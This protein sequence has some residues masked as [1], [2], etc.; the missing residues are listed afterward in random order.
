MRMKR[1]FAFII[2]FALQYNIVFSQKRHIYGIVKDA[3]NKQSVGV[4]GVTLMSTDSVFISGANTENDGSFE[5][6]DIEDVRP[7]LLKVSCTGYNTRVVKVLASDKDVALG[8]I[9]IESSSVELE[10]ITVTASSQTGFSDRKM[11]YP[12]SRQVRLSENG[13]GLLREMMIP[14]ID[15][16]S[17]R[18]TVATVD[19]GEVQ[20][21]INDVEATIQDI[22]ALQP[23]EVKRIE[24]L[25]N[26][27]LRYGNAEVVLNYIVK[28]R[29]SG[30]NFSADIMQSVTANWGNYQMSG[31]VNHRNS[32]FSINAFSSVS[33]TESVIGDKMEVFNLADGKTVR[34]IAEGRP[35]CYEQFNNNINAGYSYM[36][37]KHSYFNVRLR[38]MLNNMPHLDSNTKVYNADNPS[39][40]TYRSNLYHSARLSP[41]IDIYY[42][43]TLPKEQTLAFNITGKYNENKDNRLYT[44]ENEDEVLTY[45]DNRLTGKQRTFTAEAIY[46]KKFAKKQTIDFGIKH[47][48]TFAVSEHPVKGSETKSR[49]GYTYAYGEYKKRVGKWD[50]ALGMG[51]TRSFH[52]NDGKENETMYAINPRVNIQYKISETSKLR[53]KGSVKNASP[54]NSDLDETIQ[55]VDSLQ[56][57]RGNAGL[58][59]YMRYNAQ[60]NYEWQKG[61][62]YIGLKGTY[63]YEPD[64]IMEEKSLY[65]DKV[66]QTLDNQKEW[67][68]IRG[69]A[70]VKAGPVLDMLQMSFT[71][72]IARYISNGNSYS[73]NLTSFFYNMSLSANYKNLSLMWEMSNSSKSLRGETVSCTEN[74][75]MAGVSYKHKKWRFASV[76]FFPF[77]NLKNVTEG[78]NRHASFKESPKLGTVHKMF[79]LKATYSLSFGKQAKSGKRRFESEDDE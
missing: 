3:E 55:F 56:L 59:S 23:G 42:Q 65:E 79:V 5:F 27:G 57:K 32:E 66:M 76:V 54:G 30:G 60:L 29:L 13:L 28:R 74:F 14:M 71:G 47:V 62:F 39:D 64:R 70:T 34:R 53:L 18:N 10:G 73:H 49:L 26:P 52:H 7:L 50:Y 8:D 19:G 17:F 69:M 15:V 24:Y 51:V 36:P 78:L 22:M 31:K 21:R 72:G 11:L 61:I 35:S 67:K 41:V 25:D 40:F 77:D 63:D 1:T 37:D 48:Q 75:Q 43:R 2:L 20:L 45:N 33:D 38:L 4:A 9:Y 6:S 46:E 44:E 58:E 68:R 12:T 16:N